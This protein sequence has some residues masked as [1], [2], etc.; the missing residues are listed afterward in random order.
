MAAAAIPEV[1]V[2]QKVPLLQVT[3]AIFHFV[4]VHKR[5]EE[6]IRPTLM[7]EETPL[8]ADSTHLIQERVKGTL[9][10]SHAYDVEFDGNRITACRGLIEAYITDR[11]LAAFIS[12]SQ[13]LASF[14]F[15]VQKGS[16]S[17]GLLWML[18]CTLGTEFAVAVVKL[19]SETG[20]LS[21]RRVP[22]ECLILRRR[23]NREGPFNRES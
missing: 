13:Q 6:G 2:K 11:N 4:P 17:P 23:A 1:S 7:D 21:D 12:T 16:N 9:T 20:I 15:T 8:D 10:S 22:N 14:L 3:R 19:E 18:D 5:N